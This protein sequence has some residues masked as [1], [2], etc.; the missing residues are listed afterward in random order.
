MC[1]RL[2]VCVLCFFLGIG[3]VKGL[4]GICGGDRKPIWHACSAL[5][6]NN[7]AANVHAYMHAETSARIGVWPP[8]FR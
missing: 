3:N 5:A 2:C 6:T 7:V 4:M 1:L 8:N